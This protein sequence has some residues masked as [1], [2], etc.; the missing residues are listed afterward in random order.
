MPAS[1]PRSRI[2]TGCCAR[3]AAAHP[4]VRLLQPAEIVAQLGWARAFSPR[5]YS[6]YRAPYTAAFFE[7]LVL[8]I[9]RASRGVGSYFYKALVLDADN[10]LWGGIVGEDLAEELKLG[11]HDYPGSIYWYVQ[12]ELLALQTHGVLLCLCSKNNPA[13]VDAVLAD[14]PEMVLRDRHFAAKRVNWDDKVTNIRRLASDLDIGLDAMVYLDD[15]AFECAAVRGQLPMVRTLQVPANVYEYPAL[16]Q[17]V[18]ELFLAGGMA[19]DSAA[20]TDQYRLRGLAG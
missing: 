20:K 12:Q 19:S 6:R 7:E 11:P 15:S 13:E 10:T 8:Q 3:E 2:S 1:T 14:H 16:I 4:N 17:Q 18:K 9:S 5:F